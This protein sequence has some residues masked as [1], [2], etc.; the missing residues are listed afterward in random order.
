MMQQIETVS[1]LERLERALL[2]IEGIALLELDFVDNPFLTKTYE[3]VHSAL[4]Y[5]SANHDSWLKIIEEV[6]LS[7]KVLRIYDVD[8]I[9]KKES[10]MSENTEI[11]D[12]IYDEIDVEYVICPELPEASF[13]TII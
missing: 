4:G 11:V 1:R 5:C 3:I 8:K 6:E 9:L 10:N 7:L 2:A 12:N 13:Q